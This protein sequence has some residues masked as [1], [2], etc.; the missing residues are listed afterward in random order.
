MVNYNEAH[1]DSLKYFEGDELA[2]SIFLSKYAV[3]DKQNNYI[4]TNPNQMHERLATEFSKVEDQYG[5]YQG[6]KTNHSD[7]G[8]TR[9]H[10][11]KEKIFN[12]F[13]NFK[14]IV[15]QGSVMSV[16]GNKYIIGSLSNCI[17][18]PEVYDSIGGIYYTDQQLA[19]LSKRR[20]GVGIDLST[21][22]PEGV[23]VTNSAGST[24]GAVSFMERYSNTTREIGQS[25]RRGA[26][27]LTLDIRHPDVEKFIEIK[28]DLK[29]VT[30]ANISVKLTDDFMKAVD[31]DDYFTLRY[32]VDSTIENSL[33]N[34]TVKAKT[35]WDK[36]IK[37]AYNSAEPGVI[38][39]D[40]QHNYSTS[41]VYPNFRNVSTNPCSE[42]AMNNDS[43]RLIA[44]NLWSFVINPF[45]KQAYF[46]YDKFYEVSYES[47]RLMDDLVDLELRAIENILEKI[48]T[49]PEPD[50][51]KQ[52]EIKTWEDLYRV[53]KEG[54]RTGL[55]FTGLGDVLA[56]LNLP[57]GSEKS[58]EIV[59]SIMK[60][61]C[62][63]EFDSSIDMSIERGMF[64][65]FNYEIENISDFVLML[66]RELPEVYER[67]MKFGRRNI[68][69]S[70]IAP[71]GSLSN[72]TKTT[73]GIEPTFILS[74]IRRKK[75]N[76]NDV[77]TTVDYVDALG[78]K[79]QHFEV[80]H[81]KLQI[82][83][84]VTGETNLELSPY[85]G[86]TANDLD[87]YSRVKLQA[88]CQKY[89]THSISSTVNLPNDVAISVVEN[90]YMEAWKHGLKGITIYRDG[91][92]D[93]VL[94]SSVEKK[95]EFNENNAPKRPKELQCELHYVNI[96]NTSWLIL[97][98]MLDNKPYEIFGGI[99]NN[100]LSNKNQKQGI[101]KKQQRGVYALELEG[102]IIEN[103]IEKFDNTDYGFHTR[104]LSAMLRHGIPLQYV[105]DQLLKTDKDN[106]LFSFNK[107]ISRVLKK[108]IKEGTKQTGQVCSQCNSTNLAYQE[109]C[110]KCLDCMYS[111]CS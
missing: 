20:C 38:Y 50:Y 52:I 29:K 108:Y 61:K 110:L 51:V 92:R 99:N 70:T 8:K 59:E 96:K 7:Y 54:R 75:I 46:D 89:V 17:V 48:K 100:I 24:T 98:G 94:V 22:R 15:P 81:P 21:L 36:I 91:C 26:L 53:G 23:P 42:I 28:Q 12:Y 76:P 40:H 95:S 3:K 68:S 77:G 74:Y 88:I 71:T 41:S 5:F 2:T 47:M 62:R 13:K 9:T 73:S 69:I 34:K 55:G 104:S 11:T 44:I 84:D 82:W 6:D 31:N 33:V 63:A 60:C 87:W 67:M 86:S 49:D 32:P 18:L 19:Q 57:Y 37:S 25:G 30:G 65:D 72:L 93:G 58:L 103:I 106:N 85:F 66:S 111:K 45:T 35:I 10:L 80:V 101:I 14:Y 83:K 64:K 109:G 43:C 56:G 4:E 107:V 102:I 39:W 97:V 90:I 79:W 105:V 27:M 16:L 78:D 1:Q